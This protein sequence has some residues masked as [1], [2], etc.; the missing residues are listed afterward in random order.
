MKWFV[1][2][3]FASWHPDGTQDIFVFQ[4]PEYNEY[5]VCTQSL[6]DPNQIQMYVNG[7]MM[8]YKGV[9][10]GEIIKVDCIDQTEV[11]KLLE[12]KQKQEGK[13]QL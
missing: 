10:P 8:F 13:I 12:I 9:I 1:I 3:F 7:L 11:Q 4:E 6:V 2:I 5:S